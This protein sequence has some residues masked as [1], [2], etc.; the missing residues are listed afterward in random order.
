[1]ETILVHSIIT[2]NKG[3]LRNLHIRNQNTDFKK[4]KNCESIENYE[5]WLNKNIHPSCFILIEEKND[6]FINFKD[7]LK[8]LPKK[9]KIIVYESEKTKT[10]QKRR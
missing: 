3:I 5:K 6:M 10:I 4:I 7:L 8:E 1:M 2:S 9:Q